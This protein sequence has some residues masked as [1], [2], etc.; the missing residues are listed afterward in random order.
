MGFIDLYISVVLSTGIPDTF[1][2]FVSPANSSCHTFKQIHQLH[3][4]SLFSIQVSCV[5][6]PPL[7]PGLIPRAIVHI[8]EGKTAEEDADTMYDVRVSYIEVHRTAIVVLK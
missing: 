5:P 3:V 4:S 6:P 8:F 7:T 2:S 1:R